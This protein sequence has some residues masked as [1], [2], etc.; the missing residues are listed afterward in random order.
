MT[1]LLASISGPDE[2]E[3]AVAHGADIVDLRGEATPESAREILAAVAGRRAVS[4]GAALDRLETLADAGVDYLKALTRDDEDAIASAAP[5]G[6]RAR[7]LAIMLT[8]DGI[9]RSAIR[10]VAEGGYAGV[11]LNTTG[12]QNLLEALDIPA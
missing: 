12:G 10:L 4:A 9:D 8:E 3:S 5:L 2:A 7:L 1:L 11:V 6:K